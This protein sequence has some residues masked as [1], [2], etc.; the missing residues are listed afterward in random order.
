M[1]FF[2]RSK[3]YGDA[4]LTGIN[5]GGDTDTTDAVT[6]GLAGIYWYEGIPNKWKGE[7]ARKDDIYKLVL[8]FYDSIY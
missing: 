2:L 6:G 7:I 3:S 4:V 5:L 1:V 8:D